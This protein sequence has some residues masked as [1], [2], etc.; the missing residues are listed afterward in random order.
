MNQQKYTNTYT[1]T[2]T[3]S[4][5]ILYTGQ[6]FSFSPQILVNWWEAAKPTENLHWIIL[7]I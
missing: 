3:R 2:H 7:Q 1:H 4:F 5:E 6:R